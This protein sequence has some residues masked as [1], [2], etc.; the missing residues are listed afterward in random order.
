MPKHL[1]ANQTR[2]NFQKLI[3]AVGRT[4]APVLF[5]PKRRGQ[6]T[7]RDPVG[8][9]VAKL[10]DSANIVL[11]EIQARIAQEGIEVARAISRLHD[12]ATDVLGTLGDEGTAIN[13]VQEI[14]DLPAF[15]LTEA[16]VK[17][18]EVLIQS[19]EQ[20]IASIKKRRKRN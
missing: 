7:F 15:A 4:I 14:L 8:P 10:A 20:T 18:L 3:A 2:T 5:D 17:V 16:W 9:G 19:N 1:T 12:E 6:F 13:Q 11:S